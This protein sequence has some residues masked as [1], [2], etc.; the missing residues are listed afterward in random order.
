MSKSGRNHNRPKDNRR[1]RH[2]TKKPLPGFISKTARAVLRRHY[3]RGMHSTRTFREW[4]TSGKARTYMLK[5]RA[6]VFR[7]KE[8]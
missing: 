4:V 5:L 7:Q 6:G 2:S 3:R 8:Q 1:T